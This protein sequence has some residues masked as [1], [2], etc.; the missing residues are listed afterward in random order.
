MNTATLTAV[1][2]A[3]AAAPDLGAV[4]AKQQGAWSSGDYAIVGATLQIV[5]EDLCEAL[6]LHSGQSVLDVAAGNGNAT[7]AAGATSPR[8]TMSRRCSSAA[9]RGRRPRAGASSSRRP[10]PRRCLS[11]RRASTLW[12]PRL[13]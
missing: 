4:K 12:C 9:A 8:P 10:T 3:A 7:R 5:G 11:P 13:A 2:P 6:D 1:L